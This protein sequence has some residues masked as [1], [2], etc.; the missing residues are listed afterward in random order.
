MLLYSLCFYYG[1]DEGIT[2]SSGT[3]ANTPPP[4]IIEEIV[5]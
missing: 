1:S 5:T 3:P 2:M 4:P